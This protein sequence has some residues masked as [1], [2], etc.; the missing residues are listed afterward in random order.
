MRLRPARQTQFGFLYLA[1]LN[2]IE[3]RRALD[4]ILHNHPT[5]R[6]P[7]PTALMVRLS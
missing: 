5:G 3:F 2:R 6:F 4:K 7:G 1:G